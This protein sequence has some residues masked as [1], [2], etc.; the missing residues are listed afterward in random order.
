MSSTKIVRYGSSGTRTSKS[1]G[2]WAGAKHNI[3]G[4]FRRKFYKTKSDALA[5]AIADDE[6]FSNM[7]SPDR[8]QTNEWQMKQMESTQ[9]VQTRA[10]K[11][12]RLE[13][14]TMLDLLKELPFY[15][16]GCVRD[17]HR[18]QAV[19]INKPKI[20]AKKENLLLSAATQVEHLEEGC[21]CGPSLFQAVDDRIDDTFRTFPRKSINKMVQKTRVIKTYSKLTNFLKCKFFM[22][23]RDH[24]L[25]NTMVND[26]RIWLLKQGSK[27]ETDEDFF[28]LSQSVLVAF[29]VN[30]QEMK[31]RAVLKD[32]KN[33]DNMAHLNKT[34]AGN[35][36]K[37]SLL[38][39]AKE[40]SLLGGFLPDLKFPGA[41]TNP[42]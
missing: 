35:L 2:L 25:I 9:V 31:F 14:A 37:V 16:A 36:G 19:R 41:S 7:I 3:T 34:V 20:H 33:W 4:Y 12:E 22:R 38:R 6:A 8:E 39:M 5:K 21:Q 1:T 24:S 11:A 32:D 23:Q 40:N 26:A 30:E 15:E 29:L 13:G 18:R 27:C 10:L 17:I 28:V 42:V